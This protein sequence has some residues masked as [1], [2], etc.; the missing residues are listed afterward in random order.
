MSLPSKV[1]VLKGSKEGIAVAAT[2]PGRTSLEANEVALRVTHSGVSVSETY[3]EVTKC[4]LTD[5]QVC[6]TDLHHIQDDMVLGHE[7]VGVVEAV[8][9]AVTKFQVCVSS[10][11]RCRGNRVGFGYVK[12]GCG[13]CDRCVQ[14]DYFYCQVAPRNYGLTDHDQGSFSNYAIWTDT[15]LHKIPD[16]I[17]SAQAAPFLCAGL[18][19]FTPMVRH[20]IKPGHRVGIIGIGGLGHLAIQFAN[21]L[22]AHV[23]VFSSSDSKKQEALKLG[24]SDFWLSKDLKA[25]KP[26]LK[27]DYLVITA[28]GHPDWEV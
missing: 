1:T 3:N 2:V 4:R 24:A 21:K 25:K 9:G 11:F 5:Q 22:G 15:N 20:G 26:D 18:T 14:G 27:L 13:K 8:G 17:P 12:D 7:G 6:G 10:L 28:T 23:T 19:V 16:N